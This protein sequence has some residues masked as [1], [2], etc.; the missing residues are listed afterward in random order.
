[1]QKAGSDA[2]MNINP[3]GICGGSTEGGGGGIL[4]SVM[5]GLKG[6]SAS[7]YFPL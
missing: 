1:M 7:V 2:E 6:L 3:G 4:S 5:L